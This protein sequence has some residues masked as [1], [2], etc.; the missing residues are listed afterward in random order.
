M[1]F[2]YIHIYI[3]ICV[4]FSLQLPGIFRWEIRHGSMGQI[5][6]SDSLK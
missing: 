3:N 2:V 6:Q 5:V 1:I 4:I